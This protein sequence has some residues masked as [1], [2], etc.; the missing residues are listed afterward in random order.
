MVHLLTITVER[1]ERLEKEVKKQMYD[2]TGMSII[3][4]RLEKDVKIIKE[5]LEKGKIYFAPDPNGKAGICLSMG[6]EQLEKDVKIIKEKLEKIS[7]AL[8][9]NG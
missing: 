1:L 5:K 8:D 3:L 6:L 4:E 2:Y 7:N 9:I